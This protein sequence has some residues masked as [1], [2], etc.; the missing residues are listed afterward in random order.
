M[1][2]PTPSSTRWPVPAVPV[3]LVEESIPFDP[4]AVPGVAYDA[5]EGE[6]DRQRQMRFRRNLAS[7]SA[8]VELHNADVEDYREELR[9][10][11][12]EERLAEERRAKAEAEAAR[13]EAERLSEEVRQRTEQESQRRREELR[14]ARMAEEQERE[15]AME[16]ERQQGVNVQ[17]ENLAGV[18]EATVRTD[19]N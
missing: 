13:V 16:V 12:E 8:A 11:A 6:S 7:Y 19:H 1:S 10:R 2:T 17:G 15:H 5:P 9:V 18:S 14:A 4:E 3:V